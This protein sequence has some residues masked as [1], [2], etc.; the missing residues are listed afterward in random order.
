MRELHH[1]SD[2]RGEMVSRSL[3]ETSLLQDLHGYSLCEMKMWGTETTL[4]I[5]TY[6]DS[7]RELQTPN[8]LQSYF[9]CFSH[10]SL[11]EHGLKSNVD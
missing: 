7:S 11:K 10:L 3:I 4:V 1:A 9:L 6:S 8:L 2:F 5:P